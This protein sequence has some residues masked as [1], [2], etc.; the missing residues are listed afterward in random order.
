M[1]AGTSIQTG[2]K[3]RV[4]KECISLTQERF[5]TVSKLAFYKL[6]VDYVDLNKLTKFKSLAEK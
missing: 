6:S 4:I 5:E 2:K 3:T 1:L